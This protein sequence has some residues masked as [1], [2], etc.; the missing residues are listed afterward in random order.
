MSRALSGRILSLSVL[1][2]VVAGCLASTAIAAEPGKQIP[3]GIIG[4]DA[5]ALPWTQIINGPKAAGELAEMRIVA[6]YPGGSP[7]LPASVEILRN[8]VEPCRKLGV[9]IVDSIDTLLSKVDAVLLLSIDGRPHLAQARPVFAAKKPVFIDK[10]IAASLADAMIIYRL[11]KENNVPCF[12]SSALRMAPTTVAVRSDPAVGGVRGCDAYSPA[13]PMPFHPDLFYYG[14]HGI[15]AL[16]AIMGPGC[17]S[18]SRV[19]AENYDMVVGLW[20]GGRIGSFR[21]TR[22]GAHGYGATVF[23][24]KGIATVGKFEG[25]EPL[26]VQIVRFFKTGKAPVSPEE[27]LEVIAFMEAANESRRLGGCPVTIESVMEKARKEVA[28]R[29]QGS[30]P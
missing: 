26:L 17:K 7:E 18:V 28:A 16:F 21:G 14:I 13:S 6:G 3:V 4:M 30:S 11:A 15:E 19:H 5:H 24:K 20:E 9:E 1:L 22:E 29:K 10:P 23:G 2:A 8:S 25:Y 12:T 27:S